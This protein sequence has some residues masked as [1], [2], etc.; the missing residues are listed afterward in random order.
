MV[1]HDF[2]QLSQQVHVLADRVAKLENRDTLI[3]LQDIEGLLE[4]HER[5]KRFTEAIF[6][7][8]ATIEPSSDPETDAQYFVVHV[9]ATGTVEQA[10]RLDSDWHRRLPEAARDWS[11]WY[12]L[13][14]NFV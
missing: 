6:S 8:K 5:V 7:A 14:V 12:R 11:Q 9:R 10:L 1:S 2:Q 3:S 4:T 13:S